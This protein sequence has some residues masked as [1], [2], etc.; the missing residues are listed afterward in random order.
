MA[1][2]LELDKCN[3]LCSCKQTSPLCTLYFCRHCLC[4]RCPN[5]VSHEVDSY[6]CPN[7]LENMASAEAKMRKHRCGNC[8]DCP[9][10]GHTLST[11]ATAV[12]HAKPDEPGRT[13]AQKA[14]FLACGFCR[15]I[16][17]DSGIPDQQQAAGGWQ[18]KISPHFKRISELI[19][20][21]H[22]LAVQE[23]EDQE[24]NKFA[25]KRNYM[26]LLERYPVLNPRLRRYCSSSWTTPN[27]EVAPGKKV[28]I[29][30][31]EAS[32]EVP[33]FDVDEYINKP[34][35]IN[36]ITNIQ[37]RHLSPQ[38]Q[39][40]YTCNLEPRP[41]SLVVKRSMRCRICEH[42]LCKADFS[43]SSIKFRI[44][45]NA[46]Y[47]VPELRYIIP[48]P[49]FINKV[50]TSDLDQTMNNTELRL[51][52]RTSST[53]FA[54]KNEPI[55]HTNATPGQK[56]DI[57]LTINN[58]AHR[59]TT[60]SLRQL[61]AR[62]EIEKLGHLI[63]HKD[64]KKTDISNEAKVDPTSADDTSSLPDDQLT[65]YSTVD[66]ILPTEELK[67]AP[68]NE[69][70]DC[71]VNSGQSSSDYKDDPKI[72]AFRRGNKIGIHVALLPK[73][74]IIPT[75]QHSSLVTVSENEILDIHH[76]PELV[77]LR[78]AIC[79]NFDYKN[80]S[81]TVLT[82]ASN[83]V[84]A[85]TSDIKTSEVVTTE[86]TTST[87][88]ERVVQPAPVDEIKQ[89]QVIALFNFGYMPPTNE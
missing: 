76:K 48:S 56:I 66:V 88:L 40:Q 32:S 62:E 70:M 15:W 44:N 13:T 24:W 77:P 21:Y 63:N 2:Y 75:S 6:Y 31:V 47:H 59:T 74:N 9:S 7:C 49:S 4:L 10:C 72:V 38:I 54:M 26:I 61:T 5:C 52:R 67:L 89:I 22:H 71:D 19:D 39:P 34:I 36:K 80:A 3:L 8:F 85:A 78:A 65:C 82:T 12:V 33:P 79:M 29:P 60:L 35:N 57:I 64:A 87:T 45:L 41:K 68:R 53:L 14:Y 46:L 25:R 69:I 18:E 84:V 27:R 16:T 20:S 11:R 51:S 58:P 42:N 28:T 83:K 17:R 86:T 30:A 73:T 43:P 1:T 81:T 50:T 55:I 37:Q 23:K